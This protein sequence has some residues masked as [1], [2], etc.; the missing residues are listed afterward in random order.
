[1]VR[2]SVQM[3]SCTNICIAFGKKESHSLV[4]TNPTYHILWSNEKKI[5]YFTF[6]GSMIG[7]NPPS[8]L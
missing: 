7:V 3:L 1:M 6:D 8:N 4:F 5:E 2:L